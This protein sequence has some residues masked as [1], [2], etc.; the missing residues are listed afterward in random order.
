[1]TYRSQLM[2]TLADL[3]YRADTSQP[4]ADHALADH[5]LVEIKRGRRVAVVP[6]QHSRPL[7]FAMIAEIIDAAGP[8]GFPTLLV[9]DQPVTLAAAELAANA[10]GF[11]TVLWTGGQDND[12]LVRALTSAA[13]G[14]HRR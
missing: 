8:A 6:R 3:G 9:A 5:A 2:A 7:N 12:K 11:E 4:E 14:R 1:M 13:A 10:T